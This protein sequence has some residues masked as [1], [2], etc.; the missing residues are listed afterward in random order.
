MKFVTKYVHRHELLRIPAYTAAPTK[1][2]QTKTA[3][4]IMPVGVFDLGFKSGGFC[5]ESADTLTGSVAGDSSV[6]GCAG[7]SF[8]G[9]AAT[10]ACSSGFC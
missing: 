7:A 8:S 9:D 10:V 3:V 1:S 4:K 5:S 6:T 2:R